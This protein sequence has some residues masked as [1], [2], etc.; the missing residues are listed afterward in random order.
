MIRTLLL[1]PALLLAMFGHSATYYVSPSGNDSNSG[2]SQAQA[3]RTVSRAQQVAGSLQP[4]DQILFQRGGSYPGKLTI[5]SNGNS[6]NPII[7]GAYGDGAPPEISGNIPV[8][9]WTQYQGNIWRATVQQPVTQ[10]W[11]NGTLQTLARYPNTGWLSTNTMTATSITSNGLGQG[12]GYWNGATAVIRSTNWSYENSTVSSSNN[13]SIGYAPI[14]YNSGSGWGFFLQNKL[15]ELDAPGEWFYDASAGHLYFWAPSNADPNSIS[16]TATVHQHG[17]EIGWQRQHIRVEG[18]AFRRQSV[19]GVHNM[20]GTQIRVTGCTFAHLSTAIKSQGNNCLYSGNTVSNTFG[21][22]MS[23]I[24]TNTLV[25]NNQFDDIALIAGMG[26][27]AWGYFGMYIIGSGNTVRGNRLETIGCSGIFFEGNTLVERNV[28]RDVMVILNDGGGIH[29]DN[30]SGAVV[31]DNIV[32]DVFGFLDNAGT[33]TPLCHGIFV[34]NQGI[35]NTILRRNTITRCRGSGILVDHT[36]A[37]HGL[38]IR[39]NV[40][41]NNRVQLSIVDFSNY[42]APGATPPYYVA[43]FN[44]IYSG[45]IMYSTSPDQFCMEQFMMNSSTSPVDFGTFS[46][47]KYFSPYNEV[48]IRIGQLG[49][50]NKFY[51]LERWQS[52]FNKDQGSTRS[53]HRQ[54]LHEVTEILGGNLTPNGNFDYNVNSW[55][56]WPSQGQVT[57][58]NTMLDNGAL[59]VQFTNGSTYPEF[60]LR[61]NPT[62]TNVQNGQW[63]ELRYSVQSNMIGQMR[64][65]FKGQSQASGPNF[66]TSRTV[67]FDTERRDLRVVFQSTVSEPGQA[68]FIN[69]FDHSTYWLDNV[70]LHRVSVVE[71]DP[72]ERHILLANEQATTQVFGLNGCWRDVNGG[73]HSGEISIPA[74]GSV[75]LAK[76]PDALCALSTEIEEE[77]HAQAANLFHPNPTPAGGNLTLDQVSDGYMQM[78]LF[79]AGGRSVL[80]R[81]LAPGTTQFALDPS[82]PAGLY[83]VRLAQDATVRQ[84]RLI[85]Q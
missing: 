27:S 53:P 30:A 47:N 5:N 69:H 64:V 61:H 7:I 67:P 70:E 79:D 18:M 25:E 77:M 10:V 12:N 1:L 52:E 66:V 58:S 23:L 72:L 31:Q 36:M 63:Y 65:E 17:L 6:N 35:N 73:L 85:V 75:I 57:H 21:S 45:N 39:D 80:S 54:E 76:E 4:G 82:V 44:D 49:H 68:F 56:G 42:M 32:M 38:Q 55:S 40:L 62:T 50:N 16:V 59:R 74:Y 9:A 26:E 51:A 13:N 11:V 3:W 24:E 34:G 83:I 29:F 19:A 84:Q 46:N 37:T 81:T 71:V 22:G 43:Q 20:N 41:F 60:Y 33:T 28:V 48:S 2:T 8:N 15:S 78:D 14:L